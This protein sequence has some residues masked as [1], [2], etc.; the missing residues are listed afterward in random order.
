MF[1]IFNKFAR[2]SNLTFYLVIM[3]YLVKSDYNLFWIKAVTWQH[4]EQMKCCEYFS[5]PVHKLTSSHTPPKEV[6]K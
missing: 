5:D 6:K 2:I 3:G 1:S 4:L